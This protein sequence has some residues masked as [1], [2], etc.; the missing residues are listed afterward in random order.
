MNLRKSRNLM[1]ILFAFGIL[2]IALGT[3]F[4]N[5]K[6]TLGFMIAG[7]VVFISG[8]IQAFIFYVCPHCGYSLMNIRGETP[9][10]CPECGKTLSEEERND[11]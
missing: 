11:N 4:E 5:G 6:V 3:G 2:I 9:K 1:W 8:L 7:T 10:H